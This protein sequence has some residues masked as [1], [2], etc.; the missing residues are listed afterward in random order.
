MEFDLRKSNI[1]FSHDDFMKLY[2]LMKTNIW[3]EEES[4]SLFELWDLCDSSDKKDLIIDLL[5]KFTF[6]TSRD[7]H[8]LGNSI[9]DY[10]VNYWKISNKRTKI[11]ALSDDT[12]PDGSQYILQAIKNKFSDFDTWSEN[13]FNNS[14]FTIGQVPYKLRN[15]QTIILIDD[16][17]GTAKTVTRKYNWLLEKINERRRNG[18]SIYLVSLAIMEEATDILNSLGLTFY[19]PLILKKGISGYYSGDVLENK[20]NNMLDLESFLAPFYKREPLPSLGHGKSESIFSI[21]GL[22]VPNN[23]FPIFWWPLF[24]NKQKRKTILRRIR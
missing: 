23:V 8:K 21:E 3:L 5:N 4:E 19:S 18:I 7:I 15:N 24:K 10:I 9:A 2:N 20:I 17:I 11:V 14:L 1:H 6:L 22:N 16:F 12:K 13:N